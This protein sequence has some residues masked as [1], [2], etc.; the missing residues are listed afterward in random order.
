VRVLFIDGSTSA[1]RN[2]GGDGRSLAQLIRG[3]TA[4]GVEVGVCGVFPSARLD[5]YAAAGARTFSR[6]ADDQAVGRYGRLRALPGGGLLTKA[7]LGPRLLQAVAVFRPDVVHTNLLQKWDG[8]D[9]RIARARGIR[10]VGHLRSLGTQV[11][12]GHF[13]VDAC[14]AI[15]AVSEAV[16][17]FLAGAFPRALARR[18]YDPV[19]VREYRGAIDG[20]SARSDLGLPT[21]PGPLLV[22]VAA[23]E[24]RKGHDLAIRVL[25]AVRGHGVPAHLVVAGASYDVGD[26]REQDRLSRIARESGVIDHVTFVGNVDRMAELYAAA[27]VVYALSHDG[28]ALGRVPIEAAF[29]ERPVVATAAGATPE[30]VAHAETGLLV[31]PGDLSDAVECTLKLLQDPAY[32]RR[33]TRAAAARMARQFS[34]EH[35]ARELGQFYDELLGRK[36]QVQESIG[37]VQ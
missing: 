37:P 16:R 5:A 8:V 10:T 6:F 12:L 13:D 4:Q 34:V 9:L 33:V 32:A 35:S 22:S 21:G 20:Q 27:D 31:A 19:D 17:R 28:E 14:D 23:L 1:L 7:L 30:I 3:L 15:V 26:H 18:I 24:P 36:D 25:G 2:L 11:T 29:A